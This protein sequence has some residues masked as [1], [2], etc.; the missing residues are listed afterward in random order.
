MVSWG[1]FC[2]LKSVSQETLVNAGDSVP[3]SSRGLLGYVPACGVFVLRPAVCSDLTM[4]GHG[5]ST[6][7]GLKTAS[8]ETNGETKLPAR[9]PRP[10][11]GW[12][13][14][15]GGEKPSAS[16]DPGN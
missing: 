5:G 3:Y 4:F 10:D 8:L 16:G 12:G 11:L 9:A 1:G 14:G 6:Q 13:Q 7:M 15:A 2:C